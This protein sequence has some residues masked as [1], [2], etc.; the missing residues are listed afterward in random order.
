MVTSLS[1]FYRT[2]LNRGDNIISVR[3]E[4]ENMKSYVDIVLMTSGHRFDVVCDL[5][6]SCYDYGTINL[7]LQPLVEN[8]VKHGIN[9]KVGRQR[10]AR[11]QAARRRGHDR[12]QRSRQRAGDRTASAKRA[13]NQA[14]GRLRLEERG[15]TNQTNVRR[16]IRTAD[17]KRGRPGNVHAGRDPEAGDA[18]R[19]RG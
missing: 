3:D 7:I 19:R 14:H 13:A 5:D 11:D 18:E 16:R 6:E 9:K 1:K 10:P 17:R 15:R 2:A 4:I 8:A 12:I